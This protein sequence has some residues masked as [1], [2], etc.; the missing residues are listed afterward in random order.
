[1]GGT[2]GAR[3]LQVSTLVFTNL[4]I[5]K[6]TDR[7]LT[8][9][10]PPVILVIRVGKRMQRGALE[11]YVREVTRHGDATFSGTVGQ[12]QLKPHRC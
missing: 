9:Q 3:G 6:N 2:E 12:I 8:T 1:M 11:G 10:E 5:A 4:L 7:Y